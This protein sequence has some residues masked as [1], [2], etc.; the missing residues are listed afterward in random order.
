MES[1][2]L[3]MKK[4][5]DDSNEDHDYEAGDNEDGR[6]TGMRTAQKK[7]EGITLDRSNRASCPPFTALPRLASSAL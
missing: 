6:T 7:T 5:D 3:P 4:H 2:K 1:L